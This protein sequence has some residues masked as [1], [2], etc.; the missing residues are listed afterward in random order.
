MNKNTLESKFGL[1]ATRNRNHFVASSDKRASPTAIGSSRPPFPVNE[2]LTQYGSRAPTRMSVFHFGPRWDEAVAMR[3]VIQRLNNWIPIARATLVLINLI[4]VMELLLGNSSNSPNRTGSLHEG[5][6]QCP[7]PPLS[8]SN[9]SVMRTSTMEVSEIVNYVYFGRGVS[10]HIIHSFG[11]ALKHLPTIHEE[12]Y[13]Y[14][15]DYNLCMDRGMMPDRRRGCLVYSVGINNDWT[16]DETMERYGCQVFAFDP[17]MNSSDHD[18]TANIHFY[19]LGIAAENVVKHPTTGWK[20]LTLD[21]IYAMLQPRHGDVIIDLLKIDIEGSEW[22]VIPQMFASGIMRKVRQ[23]AF[24]LHFYE[25]ASNVDYYRQGL[26][27]IVLLERHGFRCFYSRHN[28]LFNIYEKL[29]DT[30][31][32]L[33]FDMSFVNTNLLVS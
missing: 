6:N 25:P 3:S 20:L 19:Q 17:S 12:A 16:F 29:F 24:E 15:G 10:C 14:G 2:V 5:F 1:E 23:F 18:H 9:T 30:P 7:L 33:A 27:L 8:E 32:V 11:G 26:G 13:W 4:F 22:E 28:P 21:S 31:L